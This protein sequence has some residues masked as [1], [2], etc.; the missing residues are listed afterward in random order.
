MESFDLK[1]LPVKVAQQIQTLKNGA[2][3]DNNENL[4]IFGNPGSGKTHL[5]CALAHDLIRQ[6]KRISFSTC[7]LLLQDL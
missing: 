6:D 5:I 4:L 7:A 2:F 3:I 1:R